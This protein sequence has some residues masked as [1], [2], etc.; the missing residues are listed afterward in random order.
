[1]TFASRCAIG[2]CMALSIPVPALAAGPVTFG[3]KAGIVVA[4]V[5]PRDI[6]GVA[7]LERKLGPGGGGFATW[8]LNDR[9][10][11][12]GELLYVSKGLSLG[13]SDLTNNSGTQVGTIE[14]LWVTDYLEI[15]LL[16]RVAWPASGSVRPALVLGPAI[17][18]KLRERQV[19][20]GAL[21]ESFKTDGFAS[22]DVGLA[23]GAEVRVRS[24]PG[25]SLIEAR[26]TLGLNNVADDFYGRQ[27]KNRALTFMA[28]YAF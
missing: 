5:A 4:N 10:A 11:L 14:A 25:W 20:T 6:G 18:F 22:T 17:A 21:N 28:G 27:A 15:P 2:V 24:G 12:R 8:E 9:F 19:T 13:E 23:A 26:Y 1:M 7:E 16:A 3:L